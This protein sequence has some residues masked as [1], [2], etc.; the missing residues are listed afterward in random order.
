[1]HT[2]IPARAPGIFLFSIA[3]GLQKRMEA[4]I[5]GI[6]LIYRLKAGLKGLPQFLSR[7][8]HSPS[9]LRT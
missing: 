6:P 1:M 9:P 2:T 4:G 8:L 3:Y 7:R 5:E